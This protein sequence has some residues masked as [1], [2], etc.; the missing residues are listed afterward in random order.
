MDISEDDLT[1]L[2]NRCLLIGM[3]GPSLQPQ[4][5]QW[6]GE[7]LGGVILFAR[8]IADGAQLTELCA[9]LR[10]AARGDLIIAVDEE[11]GDVTR[12]HAHHGSPTPGN[13]ALGAID[14]VDLTR[15]TA[16]GIG[17]E[18]LAAG[19]NLNLAPS[20]DVNTRAENPIIGTRSFGAEPD[21]VARHGSAY[22][23]GLREAG[24]AGC[25]KHFPGHG[26]T[27]TDSHLGLPTVET[28]LEPHLV[29]F[30]HAIAD[31]AEAIMCAH[32]R[33]PALD[34]LPA[35]LSRR[36]LTGLLRE[37]LGFTGAVV[38]DSLTM[39]A[40]SGTVGLA[41]GCVQ[42]LWA[43]ADLLC[44]NADLDAALA[45]R[46]HV[47]AAVRQG[48]LPLERLQEAATRVERLSAPGPRAA[49]GG[50]PSPQ[51]EGDLA[52]RVLYVDAPAD[53]GES[54]L[55][56]GPAFVIEAA[57]P[58]PGIEPSVASLLEL[59]RARHEGVSGVRLYEDPADMN[60]RTVLIDAALREATD[61]PLVLVVRDAHR[62]PEQ[63]DLIAHV[64]QQRPDALVVGTGTTADAHLAPG[65]YVGSRA[66]ARVNLNAVADLVLEAT[67][68]A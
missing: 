58:R 48:R 64:H 57:A 35:T 33:Y 12:L 23:A 7:G 34:D 1:A 18:L 8:N 36:I 37:E 52:R 20:I 32:I 19:I 45:A 55:P 4:Y 9:E 43:G 28:D 61:R 62:Y 40:I 66:G 27:V 31:G 54:T 59:L 30:Q 15:A 29:P 63:R 41:E 21:L 2:V 24:I 38:T 39:K 11:G 14:D 16:R 26:D 67:T 49:G 44:M 47:V 3:P 51:W 65:R 10:T 42:A 17:T 46:D 50:E 56:G 6:L 13:L 60:I 68:R 22:L 5:A 25:A 53:A